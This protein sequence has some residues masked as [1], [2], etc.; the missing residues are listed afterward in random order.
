[1]HD[2]N[3]QL[4]QFFRRQNPPV[5][6]PRRGIRGE[7]D[8]PTTFACMGMLPPEHSATGLVVSLLPKII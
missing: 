8:A 4:L 2:I 3:S 5:T 7:Q 1:M 6:P